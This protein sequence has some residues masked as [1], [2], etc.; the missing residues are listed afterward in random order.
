M[1]GVEKGHKIPP[2]ITLWNI[3]TKVYHIVLMAASLF[4]KGDISIHQFSFSTLNPAVISMPR[5]HIFRVINANNEP[6]VL[7]SA[8]NED[9]QLQRKLRLHA[10]CCRMLDFASKFHI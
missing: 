5:H 1:K 2:P 7:F 6:S 8:L 10:L 3:G 4:A 9:G